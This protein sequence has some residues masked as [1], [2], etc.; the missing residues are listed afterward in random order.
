MLGIKLVKGIL[1]MLD[2]LKNM[3]MFSEGML[4]LQV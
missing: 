2:V 1:V 3:S 4:K